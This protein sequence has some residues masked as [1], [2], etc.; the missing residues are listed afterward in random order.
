MKCGYPSSQAAAHWLLL[1]LSRAVLSGT[2]LNQ[3]FQVN[4]I[5]YHRLEN[6]RKSLSSRPGFEGII[7]I[8]WTVPLE[9][10]ASAT[11]KH[12]N[13]LL[14]GC[15]NISEMMPV[16][17]KECGND[18]L[19]P[20]IKNKGLQ[21]KSFRNTQSHCEQGQKCSVPAMSWANMPG[22]NSFFTCWNVSSAFCIF[23][24]APGTKRSVLSVRCHSAE[25]RDATRAPQISFQLQQLQDSAD[26][27]SA[28]RH[29][30]RKWIN[31]SCI[32]SYLSETASH[33]TAISNIENAKHFM[34]A[35]IISRRCYFMCQQSESV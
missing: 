17:W 31:N 22:C 19:M 34:L 23:L 33:S 25:G 18:L 6:Q 35:G 5:N 24:A 28:E 4:A 2:V 16:V 20:T 15:Q 29:A 13:C 27:V 3:G 1:G 11:T 32:S 7:T 12:K 9:I 21:N 8:K 30:I 26:K 10:L 14:R